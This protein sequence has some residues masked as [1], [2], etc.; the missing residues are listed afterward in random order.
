MMYNSK[1]TGLGY[2]VPENVV[3]N[4]DLKQ[5]MDT[6]DEWV[7]ESTGIKER[8]WIDPATGDN[9]SSGVKAVCIAI[10]RA[11]LTK[12]DIDF[13]IF[14]TLSQIC[15]FLVEEFEQIC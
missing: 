4:N 15:I 12:E 1:I 9:T 6:S 5:W 13:I 2:Y 10:D 7:Q 14:A 3:T 11:G 8:R